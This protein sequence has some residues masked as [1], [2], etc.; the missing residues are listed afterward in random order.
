MC[1]NLR[2][3]GDNESVVSMSLRVI[4]DLTSGYEYTGLL[5]QVPAVIEVLQNHTVRMMIM[6][7][8]INDDDNQ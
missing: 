1:E 7:M 5:L 8:M 3:W 4:R 2:I 6:L